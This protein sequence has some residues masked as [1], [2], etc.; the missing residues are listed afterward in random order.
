MVFYDEDIRFL[1]SLWNDWDECD[2]LIISGIS[3]KVNPVTNVVALIK[4]EIPIIVI[5]KECILTMSR[6][7]VSELVGDCEE[8]VDEL[9][10]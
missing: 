8:I 3:L 9:Q 6:E 4:C 7:N 10:N 5:N 2:L 1:G